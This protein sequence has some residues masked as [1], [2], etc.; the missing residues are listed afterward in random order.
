MSNGDS[1][2]DGGGLD[3]NELSR[4]SNLI[5]RGF[6]LTNEVVL[7][8]G[9]AFAMRPFGGHYRMGM[10]TCSPSMSGRA[11]TVEGGE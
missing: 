4:A 1:S 6:V 7:R 8:R 9:L 10:V 5:R 11:A 3:S 2:S